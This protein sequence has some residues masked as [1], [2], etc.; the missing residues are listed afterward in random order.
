[1]SSQSNEIFFNI[2]S[3]V[4]N[5]IHEGPFNRLAIWFQGC[6]IGCQNCA[7]PEMLPFKEQNIVAL[8]HLIEII[9]KSKKDYK[10]EGVTLLGG[11]PTLQTNIDILC[12]Y[13]KAMGL[14]VILYTGKKIEKLE[15]TL[16][17]ET[18]LIIDGAFEK[19]NI[20]HNQRNIGSLNQR[21]IKTTNRY[22]NAI[23]WFNT[24]QNKGTFRVANKSILYEGNYIFK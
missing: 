18:D 7:N 22:E 16:I 19:Q 23:N 24:K 9:K 3:I 10:I 13:I 4:T 8:K 1:M 21:M 14:G 2:H 15:Q 17:S 11:E 5:T 6:N 20:N 12:K